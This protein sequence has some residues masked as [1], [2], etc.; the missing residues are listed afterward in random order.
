MADWA[1]DE[2]LA[3]LKDNL[4]VSVN[5][6]RV[7]A[8]AKDPMMATVTLPAHVLSNLL[9]MASLHAS[10]SEDA[11]VP[12]PEEGDMKEVIAEN[13][14]ES[15]RYFWMMRDTIDYLTGALS[16]AADPQY[17]DDRQRSIAT[18]RSIRKMD[19]NRPSPEKV[20]PDQI[21][22]R[23]NALGIHPLRDG[24]LVGLMLM[25]LDNADQPLAW[26][27]A[28][29]LLESFRREAQKADRADQRVQDA[30]KALRGF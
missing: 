1:Y 18:T 17:G 21:R 4:S 16:K 13:N 7:E 8:T 10:E 9:T 20:T 5:R 24:E 14:E 23:W 11:F 12:K 26:D 30:L 28:V 19:R 3:D 27:V 25:L 2:T 22:E 29:R 6:T 15:R